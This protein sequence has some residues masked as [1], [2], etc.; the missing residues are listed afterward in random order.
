MPTQQTRSVLSQTTD[1][2]KQEVETILQKENGE[3]R[4]HEPAQ[5]AQAANVC[6]CNTIVTPT[7][8]FNT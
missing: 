7:S 1:Y 8:R 3:K 5:N 6:P 4:N 2:Y